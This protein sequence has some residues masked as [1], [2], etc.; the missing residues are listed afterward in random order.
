LVVPVVFE[1]WVPENASVRARY[2]SGN[3]AYQLVKVDR[4]VEHVRTRA[5]FAYDVD[6]SVTGPDHLENLRF[7]GFRGIGPT[8]GLPKCAELVVIFKEG[9]EGNHSHEKE[10][11]GPV[12]T[13]EVGLKGVYSE[14][15][16]VVTTKVLITFPAS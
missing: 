3:L 11:R 8:D 7:V 14:A 15:I 1:V 6:V 10:P 2:G 4:L 13:S 5:G 9:G 16:R 12:A